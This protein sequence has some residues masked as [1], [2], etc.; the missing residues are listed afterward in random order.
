MAISRQHRFI[1][2]KINKTGGSSIQRSLETVV[3]DMDEKGH[4]ILTD[5]DVP[6]D[7][8]FK[9]SFVRNPWDKMVSFYAYHKKR[10][11]DLLPRRRGDAPQGNISGSPG[12]GQ[13][14]RSFREFLLEDLQTI[15][16]RNSQGASSRQLRTS[17][18]LDWLVDHQG[19]VAM[20]F[21]GRFE[22]LQQDFDTVRRRLGFPSLQLRQVNA[23]KHGHYTTYYDDETCRAV[24]Q[25]FQKD[26]SYF[27]Y[28]FGD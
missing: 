20:D 21:I 5:Y 15:R 10:G 1:F 12:T 7:E 16:F 14:E 26:I 13:A 19:R 28:R 4:R 6:L 23:S 25:A 18:Q 22:S 8:F 17:N 27:G 11:F 3:H 2:I 24:E 9:F